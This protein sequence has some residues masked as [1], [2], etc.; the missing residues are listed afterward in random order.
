MLLPY[1]HAKAMLFMLSGLFFPRYLFGL[2]LSI[3]SISSIPVFYLSSTVTDPFHCPPNSCPHFPPNP[4]SIP[5]P[6]NSLALFSL[7]GI[8]L[9]KPQPWLNST[10]LLWASILEASF[11]QRKTHQD[12]NWSYFNF[13]I[14]IS[15]VSLTLHGNYTMF[16]SFIQY[17]ALLDKYFILSPLFLIP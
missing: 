12:A 3:V 5:P 10:V 1:Y 11:S 15:T 2:V 8:D 14:I 16:L 17:P 13:I 4:A 9:A 7:H 6:M